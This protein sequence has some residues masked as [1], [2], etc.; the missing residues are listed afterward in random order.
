MSSKATSRKKLIVS[1]ASTSRSTSYKHALVEKTLAFS[2]IFRGSGQSLSKLQLIE[3]NQDIAD[4]F[5]TQD[6]KL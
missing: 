3:E 1:V 4:F 6:F 2:Q 5:Q